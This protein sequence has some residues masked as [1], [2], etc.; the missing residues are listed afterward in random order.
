MPLSSR[1][2]Q[3]ARPA[4]GAAAGPLLA[5]RA[6]EGGRLGLLAVVRGCAWLWP[7]WASCVGLSF[8]FWECVEFSLQN[9][10]QKRKLGPLAGGG[11]EEPRPALAP[12]CT[13][14]P[15][16]VVLLPPSWVLGVLDCSGLDSMEVTE[17]RARAWG[18]PLGLPATLGSRVWLGVNLRKG[19]QGAAP[20]VS[21]IPPVPRSWL[22]RIRPV[23]RS[24]ARRGPGAG[25]S[26]WCP[27]CPGTPTRLRASPSP[28][29][30]L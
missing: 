25:P 24:A 18:Q 26:R 7:S 10:Q 15:Q 14:G 29:A 30:C 9:K 16:W 27:L 1:S 13:W 20:A 12:A 8:L 17:G 22:G 5:G 11:G 28:R 4:G 23:P 19:G 21:P 3:A 2:P 6:G